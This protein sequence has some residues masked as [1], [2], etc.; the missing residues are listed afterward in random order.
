M[1]YERFAVASCAWPVAPSGA[2]I[3][4]W[5][6]FDKW[7][8]RARGGAK[9]ANAAEYCHDYANNVQSLTVGKYR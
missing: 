5:H 4:R 7:P 3:P 8:L 1:E 6:S 2:G 9:A